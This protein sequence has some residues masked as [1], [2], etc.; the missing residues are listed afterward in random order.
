MP[1]SRFASAGMTQGSDDV[2]RHAEIRE[3]PYEVHNPGIAQIG[4]VF[5]EGE[6]Q[7]QHSARPRRNPTLHHRLDQLARDMGPH[8]I[9]QAASRQNDLGIVAGGLGSVA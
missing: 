3:F 4:T 2:D 8:A 7:Y 5:F 9:V 6:A 1:Y